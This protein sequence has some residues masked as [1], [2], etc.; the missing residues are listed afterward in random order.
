MAGRLYIGTSGWYY[1]D[2]KP[3]LFPDGRYRDPLRYLANYFNAAEVNSTYYRPID[4]DTSRSW[5]RRLQ[6]VP[7]FQFTAKLWR[8]FTHEREEPPTV[9]EVDQYIEGLAP[10]AE[11]GRLGAILA[12][13]PWSFRYNT[14]NAEWLANITGLFRRLAPVVVEVR[15]DSWLKPEALQTL[16]ELNVGFCNI[17][18]PQLR[19]CIPPTDIATS[20]VGYVRLHGRNAEKWFQHEEA[21]ERYDYLYSRD[22]LKDWVPR[23]QSVQEKTDKTFVFCNNHYRAKSVA[24]ALELKYLLTGQKQP[25]P[26]GV[27]KEYPQ[28]RDIAQ[29]PTTAEGQQQ[30]LF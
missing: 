28:L 26:E 24:N 13:F 7:D 22:E 16:R 3:I 27:M 15:H 9:E 29:T 25:V 20:N 17:D 23:I 4:P 5:L 1:E 2:W 30:R 10:V 19:H 6:R 21:H 14:E 12:Q 18:Q 8:R 11:A